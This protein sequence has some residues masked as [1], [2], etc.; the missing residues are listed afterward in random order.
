MTQSD[1][2][3]SRDRSSA[4]AS[5][6]SQR[7]AGDHAAEEHVAGGTE[8]YG[9]TTPAVRTE[10]D[11][12]ARDVFIGTDEHSHRASNVSWG[13]IFAGVVVFIAIVFVFSL[14]S[15]GLGLQEA[16]GVAVG[17]WSVIALVLALAIAGYVS[18]VLAVRAGLL[19]GIATW[20][21]SL[22]AMLVLVGWLGA[23][24]L[25]AVGGAVGNLAESA[26]I[27]SEDLGEAEESAENLDQQELDQAQ[28][29][30][31]GVAQDAQGNVA[32][33]AWWGAG[34]LVLGAV[35]AGFA[36]AAGARSAHTKRERQRVVEP[37][38]VR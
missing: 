2:T 15:L 17:I 5:A 9:A 10:D 19:H 31:E 1:P 20:A 18:G 11:H 21:T 22:V 27:T 24:V 28:Q 3:Q 23:S 26:E 38:T 30:A 6:D 25:G 4:P 7:S 37:R 14:I 35:V 29:Q 13:A 16:G 36:G 8:H 32:A 12:T 34:G 33:G